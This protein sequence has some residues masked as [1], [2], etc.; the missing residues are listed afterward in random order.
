M[1]NER[2]FRLSALSSAIRV[3][4]RQY[5]RVHKIYA[6]AAATLDMPTLPELYVAQS[7]H[8]NAQAVGLDKPFIVVN[9]ACVQ[10][11]DDAELRCLLGHELGHVG[12]GHAL[13]K[14]IL[15]IV[16]GW[17]ANLSW[18]P[19]GALALRGIIAAMT[20]WWRKAELSAD[21]AGLLAGQDPA[22][23]LRLLMKLAGGGDLS[24]IDTAA[25][26]EQAAEYA[27]GGDLRDSLH[28]LRMT[29]GQQ[30][31]RARG[32][33]RRPAPLDRLRRVRHDHR[34]RVPAA[35]HRRRRLRHRRGQSRGPVLPG[36]VQQLHRPARRTAAPPR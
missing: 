34:R 7:P 24:Q 22:A 5:P 17:A 2:A 14:T 31:P 35:R 9:S 12:S 33:C 28:K 21:R 4:H 11:L 23:S 30:P 16:S 26:L 13:Y 25:F 15:I 6:E 10:Q 1:W 3:D 18:L 19:V 27:G 36:V 32:P 29:A 20:E 8:L